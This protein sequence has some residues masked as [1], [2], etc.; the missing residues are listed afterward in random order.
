MPLASLLFGEPGV[1][2]LPN[3]TLDEDVLAPLGRARIVFNLENLLAHER[4]EGI[5]HVVRTDSAEGGKC[6]AVEADSEDGCIL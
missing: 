6:A 3:Q 1:G 2:D 4:V 5:R